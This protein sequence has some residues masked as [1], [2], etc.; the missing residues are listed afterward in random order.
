M[1]V[2]MRT[3]GISHFK[4]EVIRTVDNCDKVTARKL[5]QE[6]IDRVDPALLLNKR[7]AY[8]TREMYNE[9]TKVIRKAKRKAKYSTPEEKAKKHKYYIDHKEVVLAKARVKYAENVAKLEA[10]GKIVRHNKSKYRG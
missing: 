8:C 6:E 2:Y 9:K 1:A 3:Y 10:E 5:E 4:M 7:P